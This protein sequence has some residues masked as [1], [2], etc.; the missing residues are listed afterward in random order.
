MRSGKQKRAREKDRKTEIITS[1]IQK[2]N[3]S[4]LLLFI[5]IVIRVMENINKK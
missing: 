5:I 4:D 2:F 1:N 3:Y